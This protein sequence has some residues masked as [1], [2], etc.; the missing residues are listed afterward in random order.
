MKRSPMPKRTKP[1]PKRNRKRA[2]K[3]KAAEFGL[4]A[5][6]CRTLPCAACGH[7]APSDPAHVRSRGAG[8]QDRGNVIPLCQ[9]DPRTGHLGCHQLQHDRGWGAIRDKAGVRGDVATAR[10]WAVG[11]AKGLELLAYGS[12]ETK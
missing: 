6:L 5:A 12:W 11:L 10:S 1:L 3:A 9:S 8:G 2:A 7:S 4:Q